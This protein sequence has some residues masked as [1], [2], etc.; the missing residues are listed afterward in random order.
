MSVFIGTCPCGATV[1]VE[2]GNSL[3][4]S[5]GRISSAQARFDDEHW[6]HY[7]DSAKARARERLQEKIREEETG[8]KHH[9]AVYGQGEPPTRPPATGVA[10]DE[11]VRGEDHG[12]SEEEACTA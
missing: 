6:E 10:S 4:Y 8:H 7:E 2:I 9:N 3:T 11:P 12:H 1:T 5:Q